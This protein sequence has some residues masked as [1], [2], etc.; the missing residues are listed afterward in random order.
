MICFQ[1]WRVWRPVWLLASQFGCLSPAALP[2]ILQW[3]LR[4]WHKLSIVFRDDF[5]DTD[6]LIGCIRYTCTTY[7]LRCTLCSGSCFID[8]YLSSIVASSDDVN[9]DCKTTNNDITCSCIHSR[10][11]GAWH[12]TLSGRPNPNFLLGINILAFKI[13]NAFAPFLYNILHLL[14]CVMMNFVFLSFFF[15]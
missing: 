1:N 14:F 3:F 6:A 2:A 12:R 15:F 11:E 5:R 13:L 10:M 4:L 9:N 8:G 7:N